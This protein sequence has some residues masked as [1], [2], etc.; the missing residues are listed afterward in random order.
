MKHKTK[1]R[2]IQSHNGSIKK[3]SSKDKE[4]HLIYL[5]LALKKV[6]RGNTLGT[7][8]SLKL[9]K[10]ALCYVKLINNT[11]W[12]LKVN[13]RLRFHVGTSE[14]LGRIIFNKKTI[15]KENPDRNVI[16]EFETIVALAMEDKV[17]IRSYSPLKQLQVG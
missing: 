14:V 15:T 5:I 4:Q 6:K 17:V 11:K 2:G 3:K 10:K 16:I 13:Q 9:S 7:I 8:N 12:K 1:V